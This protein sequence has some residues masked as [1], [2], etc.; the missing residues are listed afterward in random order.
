MGEKIDVTLRAGISLCEIHYSLFLPSHSLAT[1]DSSCKNVSGNHHLGR[2]A[3]LL[4]TSPVHTKHVFCLKLFLAASFLVAHRTFCRILLLG[5]CGRRRCCCNQ[6]FQRR[7]IVHLTF[8]VVSVIVLMVLMVFSPLSQIH[9]FLLR[10]SSV[11][12]VPPLTLPS[13]CGWLCSHRLS[14]FCPDLCL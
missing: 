3:L 13:G 8:V 14:A 5:C 9:G 10:Y 1:T 7:P 12:N 2:L 4:S 11:V 6:V